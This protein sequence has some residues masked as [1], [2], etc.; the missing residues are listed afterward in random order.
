MKSDFI[1]LILTH[2]P[3][4][5]VDKMVLGWQGLVEGE[6][7][8]L[9]GG[10]RAEYEKIQHAG[11]SFVDDSRLVTRDHQR[12]RQSYDGVFAQA[13]QHV[14]NSDAQF[15]Y[16]TEFDH[17]PMRSDVA[18]H[19][20]QQMEES[21]LDFMGSGVHRIDGTNHPHWLNHA[22]DG[23]LETVL[24]D[25]SVR[26]NTKVILTAFGFGQCWR[27][28]AF[29]KFAAVRQDAKV[30]LELWIPTVAYHLGLRVGATRSDL[31]WNTPTGVID[32]VRLA[33]MTEKPFF[34][35]PLKQYWA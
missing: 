18:A 34:V 33:A 11:K 3:A 13:Q 21:A 30:Y 29:L 26:S 28:D 4:S 32:E 10:P 15:V 19:L 16:F 20:E 9:Y 1:W 14:E 6:I 7:V 17:I 35:H 25:L 27:R 5:T 2:Q 24:S 8:V 23:E 12:E 22:H 31:E